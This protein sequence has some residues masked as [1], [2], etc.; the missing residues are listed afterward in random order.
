MKQQQ[1]IL[2]EVAKLVG[3]QPYR[4]TYGISTGKLPE[5]KLRIVGKRIFSTKEVEQV[6]KYFESKKRKED[7][8]VP[9]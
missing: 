5:P 6:R 3:V 8:H 1:M 9:K 4:I 2:N 7:N